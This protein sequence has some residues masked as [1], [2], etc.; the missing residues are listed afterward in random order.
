MNAG[1]RYGETPST[2]YVVNILLY[3]GVLAVVVATFIAWPALVH[4]GS[5]M[6]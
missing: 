6:F 2:T 5:K 3:G 4:I 1:N